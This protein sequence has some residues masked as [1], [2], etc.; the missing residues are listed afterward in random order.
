M[1]LDTG[2]TAWVL[3]SASLVLMMTVPALALF[4]GGMCRSRSVLNMMSF[5]AAGIVGVVYVLWGWSMSFGGTS[6]A[7]LFGN[8]FG[9]FGLSGAFMTGG[10]YVVATA[11]GVP[12][13]A[14]I[15]FQITFVV[16]AAA[17]IS[18]AIADRTRYAAWVAFVPLL[19]TLSYFPICHM[20]WNGG[21][22]SD[23]GRFSSLAAPMDF[24][25]GTVI[26]I[27]AGVVGLF[28]AVAIGKRT[29]FGRGPMRPHSLP[30]TM[31]GA[32]LLWFG[33]F[34]F[35]AGSAGTADGLAGLA[36]VNTT[37]ACAAMLGWL[38][39]ERVR[40][41]H[42]TSLGAAS[43]I[44]AGLVGITS[45]SGALNP[46]EKDILCRKR[47][48]SCLSRHKMSFSTRGTCAYSMIQPFSAATCTAAARVG[49]PVLAM[50]W[51][52][53]LRTVPSD[54]FTRLATSATVAPSA[55]AWRTSVS[56]AVRGE[57]PY[58]SESAARAGSTT[59][60]PAW[61]RRT[62]SARS[63]AGASLTTK[64][65]APDFSARRRKPG[66]PKVVTIR[67]F[68]EGSLSSSP[69]VAVRPS[70][71]GMST[72][73]RT[74]SGR[75]SRAAGSTSS[76]LPTWETTSISPS[77]DSR[78]ASAPRTIAWSSASITRII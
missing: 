55:A 41:G 59:R 11:T 20:V 63:L 42:A 37:A 67:T 69:A 53:W 29:G 77:R 8:P 75:C 10:E 48:G 58:T 43:G 36:W 6:V 15:A 32:G 23:E 46:V 14:T 1:T 12:V 44:V 62:D 64:P 66:R 2:A 40:D 9:R 18:G 52:R 34:G 74:T 16:I 17:L 45:A 28:L 13:I 21:I 60:N 47:R 7:G 3:M 54:R 61:T 72:S 31:I 76:P 39:T 70:V 24:A 35:N 4:Y 65:C 38:A 50:A 51:E 68:V 22:L 78:V 27:N 25:G 49:A 26:H 57:S 56:R 19:A 5:T 30:L 33:W 73:M 71:P